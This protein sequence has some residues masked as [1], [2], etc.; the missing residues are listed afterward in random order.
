M[1]WKILTAAVAV[2]AFLAG[3]AAAQQ[4]T[5]QD[6]GQA[7]PKDCAAPQTIDG[8]VVSID[9]TGGKVT[10]RDSGG[11]THEFQAS[12]DMLQTMKPGDKIEAQLREA[13]KC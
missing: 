2:A 12:R 13:P 1:T 4:P 10:V 3:P 5:P 9:Q 6:Q 11:Q 8:Q 7:A